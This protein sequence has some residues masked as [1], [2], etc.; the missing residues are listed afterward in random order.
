MN[1]DFSLFH[2]LNGFA[3]KSVWFDAGAIFLAKYLP[4]ILVG[5]LFLFVLWNFKK[6]FKPVAG[7]FVSAAL[8]K[9]VTE[10]I[11]LIWSRPRPFVVGNVNLLLSHEAS[12]SFPSLH[13]AFFFAL[14]GFL[15]FYNKKLGIAFLVAS[16]LIGL[17]RIFCGL[18]W[19]SDVLAGIVLGLFCGWAMYR[20]LRKLPNRSKI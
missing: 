10:I 7:A 16:F 3:L 11:R 8:A 14:S 13:T 2:W 1:I 19:P 18:H 12:G 20:V 17:S 9:V 15:L 6:Y 4:Y 5:V